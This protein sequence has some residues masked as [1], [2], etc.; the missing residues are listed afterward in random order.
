L[1]AQ[2]GWCAAR[3]EEQAATAAGIIFGIIHQAG[4]NGIQMDV[5]GQLPVVVLALDNDALE[6]ALKQWT[7]SPV[8]TVE[9]DGV[10][11]V[12]IVHARRQVAMGTS[13]KEVEVIVKERPGVDGPAPASSY[14]IE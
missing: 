12:K 8:P 1:P 4:S 13:Q 5:S 3:V 11:G 6:P 2:P 14:S 10:S 9:A 7:T